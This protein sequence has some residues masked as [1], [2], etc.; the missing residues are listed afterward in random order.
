MTGFHLKNWVVSRLSA[1]KPI[2]LKRVYRNTTLRLTA[3]FKSMR[4]RMVPKLGPIRSRVTAMLSSA[5]SRLRGHA[6]QAMERLKQAARWS[7]E[8]RKRLSAQASNA[9][10]TYFKKYKT[11]LYA[12]TGA[13]GLLAGGMFGVQ[14]YIEANTF[15]VYHVYVADEWIGTVSNPDVVDDFK[16]AKYKQIEQQYPDIHMI[17]NT[18]DVVVKAERA[19][20]AASD[21]EAALAELDKRLVA[22]AVGV[23]LVVDGEVIGIVRD[24]D[25]AEQ[26]LAAI[27]SKYTGEMNQKGRVGIL[28]EDTALS[29]GE[30]EVL[31]AGFVEEVVLRQK[32]IDP[33]ELDDPEEIKTRLETGDVGPTKYV[34]QE[35]D[36]V[37]CIAQRFNIPTQVIYENNPWIENDLIR[38]GDVLDLTVLQPTLSVQ[39]VEKVVEMQEIQHDTEYILDDNLRQGVVQVISPG[40]N[41][42]KYVT[43]LVTK[44]NGMMMSEEFLSEEIIEEPV[45]AVA[46]K[47]TKVVLGEGT[48]KFAWPVLNATI[49]SGFGQRWGRLHKGIDMTG[50]KSILA[51]DNGKVEYAGYKDDYGYHV[52]IDHVN[53]Y[54]TLYA[55]MSSYTVK[56]GQIVEKGEKI[57]TMG[58]TG[59]STGTHLHF[60]IIKN[61][62]VENPLKYLN[63]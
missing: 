46:R 52:I 33:S 40:K 30:S 21:D 55:H 1:L 16:V 39:T 50:N 23:E 34:V 57:G 3:H 58:N 47:G 32:P 49:T 13:L 9:I 5:W 59:D 8:Q 45:T 20:K 14:Q 62:Q 27:K 26:I 29:P 31:E 56:K 48:G 12:G 22:H 4:S 63:K 2:K 18:E 36:C 19:Y 17:L 28:S 51:A 24:K 7:N 41:G 25:E 11:A 38:I 61:G 6:P 10:I 54:K 53:G 60:E 37:S 35:G 15:E 42:S 44:I 43:F